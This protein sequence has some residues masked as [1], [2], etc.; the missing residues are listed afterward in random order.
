LI[1]AYFRFKKINAT[2]I[3]IAQKKAI[4]NDIPLQKAV[5]ATG[6]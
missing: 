6:L 5:V 2:A 4:G 3:K 1:A